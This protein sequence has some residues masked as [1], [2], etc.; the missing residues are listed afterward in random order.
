M[1]VAGVDEAGRGSLAGPVV[2]AAVI[3]ENH[4]S[5]PDINDSKILSCKQRLRLED[6]IKNLSIDWN[7]ASATV[8][9]IDKINILQASL[10]AMERA[11]EGLQV[12]PFK[13]FCDGPFLPKLSMKG[14]AV[15]AGDR[16]MKNIMSA[17]ILAKVE[18]DRMMIELD[19]V[20]PLYKF[21][22]HKGYP[23]KLHISALELYGPCRHHRKS[24]KPVTK[25]LS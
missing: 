5:I 22:R 23:T 21:N 25:C 4:A 13:V 8:E 19:K 17:S 20:F 14:E 18:R 3:L 11:V 2:A 6:Q 9:E 15:I 16:I 24:F 1:I 7:I 12:E 10:L